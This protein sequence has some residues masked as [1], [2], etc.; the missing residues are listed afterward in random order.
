MKILTKQEFMKAAGNPITHNRDFSLYDGAP[1]E[2]VCG[3]THTFS[4]F[5]GQHFGSSGASA[6]FIVQCLNN[7]NSAT[8]IVTKNKF[9]ILFDKFI[10][11]AGCVSNK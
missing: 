8:L 10:S 3:A 5:S 11:L 1:Y 4:Q 2:C 9:I 6:K 7:Q